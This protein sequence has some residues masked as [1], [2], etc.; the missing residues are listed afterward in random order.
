MPKIIH[1]KTLQQRNSYILE[2]RNNGDTL[3]SIGDAVGLT[4]EAVRLILQKKNGPSASDAKTSRKKRFRKDI[5]IE[6]KAMERPTAPAVGK[7]LGISASR[8]RKALGRRKKEL[9]TKDSPVD[10]RFSNE[11]LLNILRLSASRTSGPLTVTKYTSLGLGPT[12]AVYYA[13]FG[14]WAQACSEAGVT[15]GEAVR[16]YKRKHTKEDM[17]DYVRSYLADPRTSG[18]ADGYDKWQRT[19]KGAPSLALIRQRL[20]SWNEIKIKAMRKEQ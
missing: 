16:K 9:L 10:K 5:E 1:F 3:Q 11:E 4:R 6:I 2:R 17:I 7:N 13:R 19:V 12:V 18:S 15:P 14:S 20:G 8:V